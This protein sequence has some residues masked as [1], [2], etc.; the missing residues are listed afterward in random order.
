MMYTKYKVKIRGLQ[1][2][3]LYG[4]KFVSI[5]SLQIY[6]SC[7]FISVLIL[8][9]VTVPQK[10]WYEFKTKTK[11]FL[12]RPPPFTWH[13]LH[14]LTVLLSCLLFRCCIVISWLMSF[15]SAACQHMLLRVCHPSIMLHPVISISEPDSCGHKSYRADLYWQCEYVL[16]DTDI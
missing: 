7:S 9:L 16:T 13:W 6:L 5:A 1:C 15:G 12:S 2:V 10:T 8:N 3:W 11:S 14:T 4:K